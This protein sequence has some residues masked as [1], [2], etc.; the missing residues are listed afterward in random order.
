MPS[1]LPSFSGLNCRAF[2]VMNR[3]LG[4]S[5]LA[6]LIIFSEKS[7]PVTVKPWSE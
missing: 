3:H 2:L 7:N 6:A 4:Q 1:N 5:W